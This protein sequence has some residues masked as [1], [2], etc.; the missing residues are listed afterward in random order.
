MNPTAYPTVILVLFGL[1]L[2]LG[3]GAALLL[4][5][6]IKGLLQRRLLGGSVRLASGALLAAGAL[7][8]AGLGLA[9]QTYDRLTHEQAAVKVQFRQVAN[10]QY[11]AALRYPDGDGVELDLTGDEWQLDARVLRWK[12]PAIIAG[13]DSL[14]RI[15]RISGRFRALERE[16]QGPRTVHELHPEDRRL[17]PWELAV[18]HPRWIPWV[19]AVYG[20]ATYLPMAD[21]AAWEVVVTQ[22]GLAARPLNEAAE[23]AT[24]NWE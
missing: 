4:F 17:D 23:R 22:T 6:G 21:G 8:V 9:F 16:R 10:Q 13:M 14:F 12:G 20:S 7:A 1:W 18:A 2:I 19:D 15:E 3:L 5:G 11:V 24:R